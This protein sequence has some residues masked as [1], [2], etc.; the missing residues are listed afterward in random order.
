MS[1]YVDELTGEVVEF[2]AHSRM[3][4]DDIRKI[5]EL[6]KDQI[7]LFIEMSSDCVIGKNSINM[8]PARKKDYVSKG[9]Y[10]SQ[11]A[12]NSALKVLETKGLAKKIEPDE[13]PYTYTIDPSL[14]F[15]GSEIQQASILIQYRDGK[16]DVKILTKT[17][18][19]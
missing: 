8:T 6:T 1:K 14:M 17:K 18:K 19:D 5:F 12:L 16:R 9:I 15:K 7:K 10:G 4:F 13:K 2:G 11:N 3:M